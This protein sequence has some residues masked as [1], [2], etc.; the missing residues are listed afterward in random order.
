M[1]AKNHAIV[2]PDCDKE[3]ALNGLVNSSFGAS[4]QRCMA[5]TTAV[6]VGDTANWIPDLVEKAKSFKI[7]P[8]DKPGIDISPVCYP[9]LK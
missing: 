5:L 7:G 4:G 9:E 8:G 6:L 2:L 3:D 1:G